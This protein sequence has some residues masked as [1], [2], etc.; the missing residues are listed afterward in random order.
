MQHLIIKLRPDIAN[1]FW[2]NDPMPGMSNYGAGSQASNSMIGTPG[3]G[4]GGMLSPTGKFDQ[5]ISMLQGAKQFFMS[6][7]QGFVDQEA[8]TI[9]YYLD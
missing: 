8:A 5:A 9:N 7:Q 2:A 4:A 3:V 6:K 1:K